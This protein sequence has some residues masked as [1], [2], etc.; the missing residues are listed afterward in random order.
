MGKRRSGSFAPLRRK[1]RV[2][3]MFA[4]AP[5]CN[6]SCH[7]EERSDEESTFVVKKKQIPR[8]ARNDR[9]ETSPLSPFP[10]LPLFRPQATGESM[11][12]NIVVPELGKSVI[13]ATVGRWL[14]KEG[15]PVSVGEVVV[16]LE[17]DKVDLEVGAERGGV[18]SRIERKEGEDVKIGEVLGLIE[19]ARA[20]RESRAV[21]GESGIIS[22]GAS[23]AN[24]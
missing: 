12:V 2:T 20:A 9:W 8:S 4:A 15:D 7:S 18:L 23:T 24:G 19:D 5:R 17:T 21:S 22:P 13:E 6:Q 14:K 3:R 1:L 10:H 16:E 11:A